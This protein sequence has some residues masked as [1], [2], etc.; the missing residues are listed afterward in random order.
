M[1]HAGVETP[2][3]A[4]VFLS[5]YCPE[6]PTWVRLTTA[7]LIISLVTS[8]DRPSLQMKIRSKSIDIFHV[9]LQWMQWQK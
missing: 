9:M 5:G 6:A 7:S 3:L 8:C 4:N 1:L 2:P